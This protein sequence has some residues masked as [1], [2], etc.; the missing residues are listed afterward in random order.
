MEG[1]EPVKEPED[2]GGQLGEGQEPATEP[3]ETTAEKMASNDDE[4]ANVESADNLLQ[5]NA[6]NAEV[7]E[8]S[9][10]PREGDVPV[11]SDER[12]AGSDA[13]ILSRQMEVPN[14]KVN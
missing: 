11:H 5:P 13:Q 14:D 8:P 6:P 1:E 2:I 9:E 12:Q 7:D 10:L 3:L 4:K